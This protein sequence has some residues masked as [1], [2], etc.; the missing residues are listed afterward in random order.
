MNDRPAIRI[1]SA[2]AP[3]T[4]VRKCAEANAAATGQ[5][6]EI[7]HATAPVLKERVD[8][9][10]AGADVIVAP[11]VAMEAFASAGH[12]DPGSVCVIGSVTVGV[13]V[14]NGA[15][16]PDLSSV[17]AF[18]RAVLAADAVVY[19]LASSGQYVAKT[20]QSLGLADKIAARTVIVPNG[21]A[22]MERLAEDAALD[23]IGFGHITEI[24]RHDDLGTHLVGPLPKAIGRQTPYAV[25]LLASASRPD[26]AR[27]LVDFMAS[28]DGNRI[29]V[30]SGVV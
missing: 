16:E 29:F 24:R 20:L 22:V 2:G 23:G 15:R 8:S 11:H 4:G 9:R 28:T 26:A 10:T 3:M 25:G 19:N 17:E 27:A 7:E 14:R 21:A 13:V 12:V 18:T 5:P 30:A 6:F 1:L